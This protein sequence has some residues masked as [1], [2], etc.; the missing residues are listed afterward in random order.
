M[1]QHDLF[2]IIGAP[3][4]LGARILRFHRY[5]LDGY[6]TLR[7]ASGQTIAMPELGSAHTTGGSHG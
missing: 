7:Y 3:A 4:R 1:M 5:L 6:A 2:N